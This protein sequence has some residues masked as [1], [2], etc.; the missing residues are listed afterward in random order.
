MTMAGPPMTSVMRTRN[1]SLDGIPRP[2][3]PALDR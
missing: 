3:A 2:R 1:E